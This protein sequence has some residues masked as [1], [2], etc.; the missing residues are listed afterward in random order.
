MKSLNYLRE[1]D[2]ENYEAIIDKVNGL[3]WSVIVTY[4]AIPQRKVSASES[5]KVLSL[6]FFGSFHPKPE[7]DKEMDS[8][9]NI[10][11]FTIL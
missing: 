11:S 2:K 5:K 1:K 4:D 10:R 6:P 8:D 9:N 3:K 7:I